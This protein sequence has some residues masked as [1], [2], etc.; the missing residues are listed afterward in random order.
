MSVLALPPAGNET[1][2]LFLSSGPWE[3]K[4][5]RVTGESCALIDRSTSFYAQIPK[6]ELQI[7]FW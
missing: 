5:C 3:P 7:K 2:N 6:N 1:S 4:A